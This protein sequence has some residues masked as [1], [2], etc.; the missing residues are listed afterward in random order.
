[1][2]VLFLVIIWFN[3]LKGGPN[4]RNAIVTFAGHDMRPGDVVHGEGFKKIIQMLGR[5]KLV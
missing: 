5:K 3:R 1:M 4:R 2:S